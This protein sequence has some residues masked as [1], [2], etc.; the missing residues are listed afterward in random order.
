MDKKLNR[1]ILY[2]PG[3]PP[4]KEAQPKK[5]TEKQVHLPV[6]ETP[7][8][9]SQIPSKDESLKIWSWLDENGRFLK[10]KAVCVEIGYDEGNFSRLRK[11]KGQIPAEHLN[12]LIQVL[13]RFGYAS[14]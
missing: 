13:K 7:P 4:E 11:S 10:M 5:E 1:Q 2:R 9:K 8:Q 6:F 14:S 12:K 3:S